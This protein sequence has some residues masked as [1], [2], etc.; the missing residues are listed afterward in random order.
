MQSG[1]QKHKG[2]WIGKPLSG[3]I[4]DAAVRSSNS[5]QEFEKQMRQMGYQISQGVSKKYGTYYS[6]F[7]TWTETRLEKLSFRRTIFL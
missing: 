1:M 7:G 5:I 6:F 2:Q 4:L 3:Q